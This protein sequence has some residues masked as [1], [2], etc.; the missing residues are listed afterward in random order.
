MK[1]SPEER[2]AGLRGWLEGLA[3]E[4]P[5]GLAEVKQFL[6]LAGDLFDDEHLDGEQ[7]AAVYEVGRAIKSEETSKLDGLAR[8]CLAILR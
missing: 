6:E 7:Y 2:R 4:P 3:S 5:R 8:R 1:P